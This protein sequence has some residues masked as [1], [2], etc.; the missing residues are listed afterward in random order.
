MQ[1]ESIDAKESKEKFIQK[2]CETGFV[3]GLE[4]DE[5]F[6]VSSSD[7]YE[8]DD[9]EALELICF[10]SDKEL[11][12]ACKKEEWA[13]YKTSEIKISD[14][15]ENWCTSMADDGL[16]IGT[17]FDQNLTGFEIDPLDLVTEICK[18]LKKQ[19]KNI[20][21]ENYKSIDELVAEIESIND[22]EDDGC[23]CG[24]D[25]GDDKEEENDDGDDDDKNDKKKK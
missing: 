19:K 13:D 22:S 12:N 16:L 15:I 5:G 21:L 4:N 14:F 11:A 6:A 3:W 9:G 17:D 2:V 23:G 24:C 8:D 7:E 20:K 18:E 25:D 1:Q 10:W